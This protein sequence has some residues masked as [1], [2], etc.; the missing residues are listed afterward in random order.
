VLVLLHLVQVIWTIL[1]CE[2]GVKKAL[3]SK[4][5]FVK[6]LFCVSGSSLYAR[7][8]P[9]RQRLLWMIL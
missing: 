7:M 9:A 8:S 5:M 2:N 6:Y 1:Y 4:L 3:V